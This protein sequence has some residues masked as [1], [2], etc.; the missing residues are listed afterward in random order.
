VMSELNMKIKCGGCGKI[1]SVPAAERKRIK[2]CRCGRGYYA[3]RK[4]DGSW[5]PVAVVMNDQA[6]TT[7]PPEAVGWWQRLRRK[8]RW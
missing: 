4:S 5:R 3:Q 2:R 7:A 1:L 6:A 8:R